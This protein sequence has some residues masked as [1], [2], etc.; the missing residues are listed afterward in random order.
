MADLSS[1]E[2]SLLTGRLTPEDIPSVQAHV[3][4]VYLC[5]VGT[6]SVT[7]RD[8]F[9]ERVYPRL[10]AYC[11]DKHSLEFQVLDLNW[12][13]SPNVL[14]RQQDSPALRIREIQRCQDLS[15]GPNFI[16]FIG[17]KYGPHSV[18]DVI[19]SDEYDIIR[20]ALH[21]H[22]GRDTRH[23][24]LLDQCYVIDENNIPPVHVLK[25]KTALVPELSDNASDD[26]RL[27]GEAKLEKLYDDVRC[28]LRRGVEIAYQNGT[29]DSETRDRY[30]FSDLE[31][32]ITLGTESN[33]DPSR[34]CVLITRTIDDLGNYV[35]DPK[36][37]RFADLKY[38]ERDDRFE[39][40][41]DSAKSLEALKHRMANVTSPGNVMHYN[42][43]WRYDDVIHPQ[44]HKEYLAS[45][46]E[47]LYTSCV[48]LIDESAPLPEPQAAHSACDEARHQWS[49][50]QYTAASFYN[51]EASLDQLKTYVTGGDTVP[52]VVHGPPGSGKSK[53]ISKMAYHMFEVMDGDYMVILRY[54]G[55]TPKSRDLQ[56]LLTSICEQILLVTGR[57][58]EIVPVELNEIGQ[59]FI[60]LLV[61]VPSSK[62]FVILV[63]GLE[64]L[65]TDT[66]PLPLDWLPRSLPAHVKLVLTLHSTAQSLL[67]RLLSEILPEQTSSFLQ[68]VPATVDE[69]EDLLIHLLSNV[70]RRVTEEQLATL[71]GAID[72]EPLPLFV[73]LLANIAKD[74]SSFADVQGI[75][76]P[77]NCDEGIS[78]LF[79]SLETKHGALL[80]ARA[81]GY[82]VASETGLSDCE[83]D[84]ILSLDEDVLGEVFQN[85][86]SPVRRVPHI[87]WPSLKQDVESFLSYRDSDGVTVSTWHH[88]SFARAVKLRYLADRETV[89]LVHSNLADYFLGMWAGRMKPP[90]KKL[91]TAAVNCD[92]KV[93]NQP[94]IFGEFGDKPIRYNR[95]MYNQVPGHLHKS[96]RYTE[97]NNLVFFNYDWLN[98]KMRALSL[99]HVMEDFDLNLT[100]EVSFVEEALRVSRA[101]IENDM[102]NLPSEITGRLLPYYATHP[103]I[104][105]LIR[106]CDTD[107]LH[108]CAVV[109]NF[110]YQHIPGS[111][112]QFTL[113]CPGV[114]E[115]ALLLHED[116]VLAC[117][118]RDD[119]H[120]H[121][122]DLQSGEIRKP[123]FVSVGDLFTTPNNKYFIIV[124]HV[125]EKSIKIHDAESGNF[126][127][128]II[129]MNHIQG[130]SSLH[131][132]GPISVT[133]DRLCAIVT[134]SN[135][136][137]CICDIP[138]GE[139]LHVITLEGKAHV[140]AISPD[141]KRVF[142]NSNAF[143]LSYDLY[144]LQPLI[145]V[146]IGTQPSNLVFTQDGLRGFLSNDHD[147]RLTIMHL[148]G[149]HIDMIYRA[150]LEERMPGDGVLG[151]SV[152]RNDELILVRG[153]K[154]LLVYHRGT[155]K[156][157][158]SFNKPADVPDEFKLP[159]GHYVQMTFTRA[160]FTA[161]SCFV[162]GTMF[163]NAFLWQISSGSLISAIQAPIGIITT[164]V[165]SL[166]GQLI[167]HVDGSKNVQVWNIQEAT[168]QVTTR[169]KLTGAIQDFQV[170]ADNSIAFASCRHGDEIGLIDMRN[171]A[172]MDLLTHDMPVH[173]FAI[174]PDGDWALVSTQPR[175]K[176]SAFKLWNTKERRI[177]LEIGNVAGYCVAANRSPRVFMV[178]QKIDS[179][180][181]PYCVSSIHFSDDEFFEHGYTHA[182]RVVKA[183]PFITS[184]DRFLVVSSALEE[185]DEN[186]NLSRPCVC[187]LDIDQ[188]MA[189]ST[190]DAADM[191]FEEHL[192]D[193]LEIRPCRQGNGNFIAA[194]F[195]CKTSLPAGVADP[196]IN[197]DPDNHTFGF[198]LLDAST[199]SLTLLCLPFPA[200]S[201]LAGSNPLI[202]NQDCTF[203]ADENLNIFHPPSGKFL[204]QVP[205]AVAPPRAFAL[206][207]SVLVGYTG[208]TLVVTRIS[209]GATLARCEVHSPICHLRMC[210]DD[211]T[212]LLGCSDGTVLSYTIIEPG[213]E[214]A[215]LVLSSLGSRLVGD[216]SKFEKRL[217][218]SWDK[219]DQVGCPNYSR[220]PSATNPPSSDKLLLREIK[221]ARP[222]SDTIATVKSQ[223]CLLM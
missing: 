92:R 204:C 65:H 147:T 128:Q 220:P 214:N 7:E 149:N 170:T 67:D 122:F 129:L 121:M 6:D 48:Q 207:S 35:T 180:K 49:R 38:N 190:V 178:A 112:L 105:S 43:L 174:S 216:T 79:D 27:R 213:R 115:Q 13:L 164:L 33:D 24:P 40:S 148:N 173:D 209:D 193:I 32:E 196:N 153:T 41:P 152:S 182:I 90:G 155:E 89:S 156:V 146:P 222:Q 145:T 76:L 11:R 101:V 218:R 113:E 195:S 107:G 154:S 199:R 141:M 26:M 29:M 161:D 60:D 192:L 194:V 46:C 31:N 177:V 185:T 140:C 4:R 171:G 125:T 133:D 98:C 169:D 53:M 19:L 81:F 151:L 160:D 96:G 131:K 172:L 143:L 45:L 162:V 42:V 55:H 22:K 2:I 44:L 73:E 184:N 157:I 10:R 200:P 117:K 87:K 25:E 135:S 47:R 95:R 137:L 142:C 217:S 132:K 91:S 3:I 94:H 191:K 108:E 168:R 85:F 119:H 186:S 23:A 100:D 56:E 116:R 14:G 82:M 175:L 93:P 150:V 111:S 138:S 136:V 123:V 198:F 203:C 97:L 16:A 8:A 206:R 106:Q 17:Q 70:D 167:T 51:Q 78:R 72:K 134:L 210:N 197:S 30:F 126:L 208:S 187:V 158:G 88:D 36:V 52:L 130:K 139:V 183:K 102:R 124:D 103:N 166:S 201:Y 34:R 50:C 181:A 215:T 120:V 20:L 189:M 61:S 211:R 212:V 71:R 54:I 86:H 221:A 159:R 118:R 114:P 110:P 62:R 63:D 99:R 28:L 58:N 219:I 12:G 176:D 104:R 202:F 144:T 223:M 39:L 75:H 163:R 83:M 37:R 127:K 59:Y 109:P 64:Q 21:G 66:H 74:W 9:V 179:F 77:V 205:T 165:T 1:G 80:V 15:A 69:C 84:D 68:M 57:S 5:S 188:G 18:P